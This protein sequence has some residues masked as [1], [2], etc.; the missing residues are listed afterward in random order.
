MLTSS[1]AHAAPPSECL[2]SGTTV[3]CTYL[4]NGTFVVPSGVGQV[5]VLAVGADGADGRVTS[6]ETQAY[7]GSGTALET[8]LGIGPGDDVSAGQVLT[9]VIGQDAQGSEGG[10]PN[11]GDGHPRDGL[12][13]MSGGGGGSTEVHGIPGPDARLVVAAGGGG[14]GGS[15]TSFP[16]ITPGGNGGTNGS[17]TD[18]VAGAWAAW[19]GRG[20]VIGAGGAGGNGDESADGGD[21]NVV[22]GVGG[23]GS[24]GAGGGGG[25]GY[26]GGGGGGGGVAATYDIFGGGGGGAS[27]GSYV[28]TSPYVTLPKEGPARVVITYEA[29]PPTT[30]I[31]AGPP[32]WVLGAHVGFGFTSD[33]PAADFCAASTA[34]PSPA[35]RRSSRWLP[36]A[37]APTASR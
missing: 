10:Y 33:D 31:I 16:S 24:A 4:A 7:G 35:P 1:S 8:T 30:A 25:G 34:C 11:G 37:R 2:A 15:N 3:T 29:T 36:A 18:P 14:A 5:H 9:L 23:N 13:T 17:G 21:G 12:H 6:W 27:G 22:G 20:G 32:A 26:P 19:D 28:A